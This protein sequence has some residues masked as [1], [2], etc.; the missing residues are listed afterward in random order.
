MEM[1]LASVPRQAIYDCGGLDEE[2]DKGAA[3][4][5]KEMCVRMDKMGYQFYIDQGIEYRAVQHPR[6]TKEWDEKYLIASNMYQKHM[7]EIFSGQ[8]LRLKYVV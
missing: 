1:C 4:S 2:Y 8:R 5:E 6:L 7:Q 3:C